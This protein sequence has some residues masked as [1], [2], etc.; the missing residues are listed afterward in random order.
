SDDDP[1]SRWLAGDGLSAL[2]GVTAA[3]LDIIGVFD[4][5]L[6]L[7]YVNWTGPGMT[8]EEALGRHALDLVAPDYRKIALDAYTSV[9]RT[10]VGTR[11]EVMCRA[12]DDVR[13]YDVRIGPIRFEGDIIGVVG[14]TS[15]VTEQRRA[16]ADRDRFFSLSLDLLMVVSPDGR[17]KR[18]NPAFG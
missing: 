5:K 1:I 15:N 14:I 18:L 8:R 4:R 13:I 11:F 2:D 6:R 17:F 10:G 12:G 3:A 9:L 16:D 7:R